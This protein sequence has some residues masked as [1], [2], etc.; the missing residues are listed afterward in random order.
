MKGEKNI[1]DWHCINLVTRNTTGWRNGMIP[2]S[3]I[4]WDGPNCNT[5]TDQTSDQIC[6]WFWLADNIGF[7]KIKI[8]QN[9]LSVMCCCELGRPWPYSGSVQPQ[10]KKMS[11][12]VMTPHHYHDPYRPNDNGHERQPNEHNRLGLELKLSEYISHTYDII[13]MLVI[14]VHQLGNCC[15]PIKH[16]NEMVLRF[17]KIKT[18]YCY[19]ILERTWIPAWEQR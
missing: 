8:R 10:H 3:G 5:N 12:W 13:D 19:D 4:K 17:P 15:H 9:T 7:G 18:W 11:R 6:T 2:T 1:Y 16:G 14:G